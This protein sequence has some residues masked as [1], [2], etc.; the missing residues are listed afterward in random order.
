MK[1]PLQFIIRGNRKSEDDK[2]KQ[3][4]SSQ[5]ELEQVQ[6][7]GKNTLPSTW[8]GAD[9]KTHIGRDVRVIAPDAE[10][11]RVLGRGG[12]NFVCG[13]CKY[14]DLEKG[15]EEMVRQNFGDALVHDYEWKMRHLG[16]I[17][18]LG[19]CG[20]SGGETATSF[21]SRACDQF[22]PRKR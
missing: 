16:D 12:D 4:T 21:I 8:R 2:I 14:F 20:A 19:L 10:Q 17:D 1:N 13:F 22:R 6:W 3:Q 9:G 18:A 5:E 11:I 7:Q 15:R